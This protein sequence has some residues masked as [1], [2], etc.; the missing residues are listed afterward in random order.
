MK[1]TEASGA[2]ERLHILTAYTK[3][4]QRTNQRASESAAMEFA[5]EIARTDGAATG[6][7]S[8]QDVYM[9]LTARHRKTS[10]C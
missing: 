9:L 4:L 1:V 8:G 6:S 10:S 2:L 7:V 5:D 3:F